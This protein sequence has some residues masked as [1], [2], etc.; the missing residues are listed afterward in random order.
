MI[1]D[2][3][4]PHGVIQRGS[5]SFSAAEFAPGQDFAQI[6]LTWELPIEATN[7]GSALKIVFDSASSTSL[8]LEKEQVWFNGSP[9]AVCPQSGR[10][11]RV[12]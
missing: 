5:D 6:F 2:P 3:V 4:Q 12:D 8:Q 10:L 1:F 7:I 11:L 9:A